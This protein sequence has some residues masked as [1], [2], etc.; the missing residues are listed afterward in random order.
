[1]TNKQF[2]ISK[3]NTLKSNLQDIILWMNHTLEIN[4]QL[5]IN[6]KTK[7]VMLPY[8]E[9]QKELYENTIKNIDGIIH[10]LNNCEYDNDPYSNYIALFTSNIM[11]TI[12][13]PKEV[14]KILL[15]N[16]KG[17]YKNKK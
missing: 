5:P 4:S 16:M 17:C 10:E 6:F 14:M 12:G 2:T 11:E 15:L 13:N 1:M 3:L 9:K 7:T 8:L